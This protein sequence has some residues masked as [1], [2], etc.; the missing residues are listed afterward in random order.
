MKK[1]F[2]LLS[3][4]AVGCSEAEARGFRREPDYPRSVADA[5]VADTGVA[6]TGTP[7]TAFIDT[8][9]LYLDNVNEYGETP[10]NATWNF[11]NGIFSVC[12]WW[13]PT[14]WT[15][16]RPLFSKNTTLVFEWQISTDT[17]AATTRLRIAAGSASRFCRESTNTVTLGVQEHRCITN[18]AICGGSCAD[19]NSSMDMYK[20]G[21]LADFTVC[22]GTTPTYTNTAVVFRL[23]SDST[24]VPNQG[25]TASY[26]QVA[27]YNKV[28][29]AGEIS[30]IYNGGN[31]NLDYTL[32]SSA[33]NLVAYWPLGESPDS[34]PVMEDRTA[35]NNDL[36]LANTESGDIAP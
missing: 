12:W 35:N 28:L 10:D 17:T 16:A 20:N 9:Q 19:Q 23:N 14:A 6:D 26:T 8:N 1:L 33:S 18:T 24:L 34:H 22:S 29:S 13:T 30:A 36:T 21:A 25:V 7:D 11:T 15:V 27:I 3:L 32:L 5:G 31:R 2:L 4:F